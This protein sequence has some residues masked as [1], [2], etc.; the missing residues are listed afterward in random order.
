MSRPFLANTSLTDDR[1]IG[2]Q[3]IQGSTIFQGARYLKKNF[4]SEGNRRRFTISV[5][6]KRNITG[7][8]VAFMGPYADNSNR[9]TFRIDNNDRLEFQSTGNSSNCKTVSRF[10]DTNA[11]YNFMVAVDITRTLQVDRIKFYVNGEL[12]THS[13]N[14]YAHN[15]QLKF[16]D[17]VDHYVGCRGLS[18]GPD[19]EFNGYLSQ[20]YYVDGAALDPSHFGYTDFQTGIW[21]PKKFVTNVN[22][23]YTYGSSTSTSPSGTWTASGNGWGSNPPSHIFDDD[24]SNY[25]NNNAGGQIITWNT[26]SYNLSGKLEIECRSS[27]GLYDIYVNGNSTK[28]A[29]TPSGSDYYMVDCGTHD[30]INEIQFAGT[31]YNTGTGLGSAGIYVRGIYVDGIQLKNGATHDFGKNGFYLPLDGSDNLSKDMSSNNNHFTPNVLSATVPFVRAK[32][33]PL[34]ILNTN[35]GGTTARLGVRPDPLA[36]NLVLACPLSDRSRAGGF[37]VHHLITGSGS[38]HTLAPDGVSVKTDS[39]NFYGSSGSTSFDGSNDHIDIPSST[40][41]DIGT[42]DFTCEAYVKLNSGAGG[43]T[44]CVVFNKSAPGASSNSSF[45]FGCG[46]NGASLYLSTS[47]NSWTTYIEVAQDMIDSNYHHIVWQ[48][49]SNILQIY[50][51]GVKQTTFQASSN[52]TISQDVYTSTRQCN[53]GTQDA[54]GSMFKGEIQDLRFYK[55]VAKYSDDFLVGSTHSAVVPDS[56]SGIAVSRKFEPSSSGSVSFEGTTSYL[57]I[58]NH[59]DLEVTNQDFC[60]EAFIYPTGAGNNGFGYLFNKGFHNQITFRNNNNDPQMEC[61]FASAGSGSYDI[62]AGFASGNNSVPL[63][64]W[65]HVALTRSSGTLKWFINGEEK[66]SQSAGTLGTNSTNFSIGTYL[67]SPANYE[68]KGGIS[69]VRITVGEAVYTSNF[70][71]SS[72]PLTLTSQGVT[73]SNVKLLC[74]KDKLD[75]TVAEKIPTGSI[76]RYNSAYSTATSPFGDDTISRASSYAYLNRSRNRKSG[77]VSQGSLFLT[78]DNYT[79]QTAT[80]VFGPGYITSGKYYWEIDYSDGTYGQYAGITAEFNQSAG[81]IASQSNKSY[82][83]SQYKKL[84]NASSGSSYTEQGPGTVS[85]ALDVDNRILTAYYNNNVIQID[86]TI[87]NATTTQYAPFIFSTNDGAGGVNWKDA[88]FN[89]GQRPFIFTPPE[90]YE[91]IS[92]SHIEPPSILNPR[93]HFESIVYTPNSGGLTVTGLEFKPDLLWFKS[94][95]QAYHHYI[96]DVVRGTGALSLRPS[97][98]TP[99]PASSDATHVTEFLTN[100]FYMNSASGINDNGSGTDGC[101]AWAWKGGSP[102]TSS[103]GSVRFDGAN[104]TNLHISNNADIQLGSTSNWTIEFWFKRIGAYSD[105]DVII[106]KGTSG[107]YEWFI[108]GFADGSVDFLYSN[109]GSTTWSGQLNIIAAGSQDNDRW[110]HIAVVRNGSGANSFKMYVDG[111]QTFSNQAFDIYAGTANL[112]IGGYGGAS[113]Q[114]PPVVISN[115]RIVK[116]TS[117]YTSNFTPPTSPLTNITNT[118]LLCCQT[119]RS[120]TEAAVSPGSITVNGGCAPTSSN[121]FDAF[122]ID[123][124][125]YQNATAAGLDGGTKNPTGASVNTKA[126]FSI[127]SYT[128]TQNV[129]ASYSHGL[130]QAPEIIMVK[131]RDGNTSWGVYYS[132]LTG[133]GQNTNYMSLNTNGAVGANNS[134]TT[135]VGGVSNSFMHL[136]EDYFAPSY[137]AYANAGNNNIDRLIAYMWH[138]VPG[139]SKMGYYQGNGG[140]D[141]KFVYTGFKPAFVLLK[142][143]TDST[144]NWEIRDNKRVTNNPNNERLFPNTNDTKSVGEGIDFF[145]NGFKLRNS[146]TGSNSNDKIYIYMAFAE[147]PLTTQYGTQSNGE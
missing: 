73:S 1:V 125:G 96:F 137:N 68:F 120:A 34:P 130:N 111:T 100:G 103:G 13:E 63:H 99:E 4:S 80:I 57:E 48:R 123:G 21:R 70:T 24:Y 89:F 14:S 26:T 15:I 141:G 11:W 129:N 107:T 55:G 140:L 131:R 64:Q 40:D 94:R 31:T 112:D 17:N 46:S 47:G 65:S 71:P 87:P 50:I 128:A 8:Y 106:G 2:G 136:H 81:E 52:H 115:L 119:I 42:G 5:W 134:G 142:R 135:P 61:Y 35:K 92:S 9:D 126:G 3:I 69:N 53:I 41:F 118:K 90:G 75:S 144:N 110:Y 25:M 30:Q 10:R 133:S 45:Y 82:I 12:Q 20:F 83:G 39:K 29:D 32:G 72:E 91:T 28:V 85:F 56:P 37:D 95:N 124:V 22:N 121:P 23:N 101:V 59:S 116:G 79:L 33:G 109:D 138:S 74:C 36:S 66:A 108:E 7:T 93:K 58:P 60:F 97:D 16:N 62:A 88:H 54:Q 44:S 122:S 114:D 77:A 86:T 104:G 127:I 27:S 51:D 102:I 145:N 49:T 38:A 84:F 76:T 117:V 6:C 67:P 18:G 147:Q 113:A 132:M 43:R 139:Y 19:L 146:G 143:H 78:R 98:S 105:Y